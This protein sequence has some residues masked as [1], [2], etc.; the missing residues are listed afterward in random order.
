[1]DNER[2]QI[3]SSTRNTLDVFIS[4][5]NPRSVNDTGTAKNSNSNQLNQPATGS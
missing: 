3:S 5:G 4:K 2:E 1:M